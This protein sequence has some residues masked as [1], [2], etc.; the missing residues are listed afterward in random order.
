[1]IHGGTGRVGQIEF[2][3]EKSDYS[4]K[5]VHTHRTARGHRHHC[6]SRG[7]VAAGF[8]PGESEGRAGA[9][10]QQ[11]KTM[12]IAIISTRVI[13]GFFSG[14][15][16]RL[17]VCLDGSEL[18]HHFLPAVSLSQP[19]R[20]HD[21]RAQQNGCAVLPDGSMASPGRKRWAAQTLIGYQF[22]PGAPRRGGIIIRMVLGEWASGPR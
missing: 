10:R 19:P 13:I 15:R 21:F 16:R 8:K 22:L 11:P 4:P 7:V 20:H 17:G 12:G 14:Q 1:M 18:K 3:Y 2:D 6:H 9:V 5:G